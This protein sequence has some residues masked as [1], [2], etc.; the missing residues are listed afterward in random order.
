[1]TLS[2]IHQILQQTDSHSSDRHK[3]QRVSQ[4]AHETQGVNFP[5]ISI[6]IQRAQ[7]GLLEYPDV[8]LTLK[9]LPPPLVEQTVKPITPYSQIKAHTYGPD[10][11]RPFGNTRGNFSKV[12]KSHQRESHVI[13][14]ERGRINPFP[15]MTLRHLEKM[16]FNKTTAAERTKCWVEFNPL[17]PETAPYDAEEINVSPKSSKSTPL[18]DSDTRVVGK[19]IND[20][21]HMASQDMIQRSHTFNVNDSIMPL[22]SQRHE[23]QRVNTDHVN[24][25]GSAMRHFSRASPN[26]HPHLSQMCKSASSTAKRVRFGLG[27]F[28]YTDDQY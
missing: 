9:R 13:T 18:C 3:R 22:P 21:S 11:F 16:D 5:K 6:N 10:D 27:K 28:K 14:S 7:Q 8:K 19:Y 12:R 15:P 2:D 23:E 1:M 24:K 4:L 26:K 20:Q 25:S 17:G